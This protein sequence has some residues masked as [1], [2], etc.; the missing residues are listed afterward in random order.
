MLACVLG[1]FQ[2][3]KA[4]V[5]P[6]IC[7]VVVEGGRADLHISTDVGVMVRLPGV[8]DRDISPGCINAAVLYHVTSIQPIARQIVPILASNEI[9]RECGYGPA[10]LTSGNELNVEVLV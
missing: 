2:L 7:R 9:F 10:E 4:S 6:W 8:L 3:R 5:S 1:N